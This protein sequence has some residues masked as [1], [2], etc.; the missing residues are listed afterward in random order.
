MNWNRK[1]KKSWSISFCLSVCLSS[2]QNI[3]IRMFILIT[4]SNIRRTRIMWL[5]NHHAIG[6]GDHQSNQTVKNKNKKIHQSLLVFLYCFCFFFSCYYYCCYFF[7][8]LAHF[9]VYV[10]HQRK[11]WQPEKYN[12]SLNPIE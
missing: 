12:I 3:Q 10:Y 9:V 8:S 6:N 11:N 7:V 2:V 4:N 5:I 1:E